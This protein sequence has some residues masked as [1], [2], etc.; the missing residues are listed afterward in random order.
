VHDFVSEASL[1]RMDQAEARE[2]ARM[3][4][5]VRARPSNVIAD[6]L[7]LLY[8]LSE[9]DDLSPVYHGWAAQPWGASELWV[10]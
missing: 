4:N 3:P 1:D 5:A 9:D 6:R 8:Q 10:L 2:D 7:I